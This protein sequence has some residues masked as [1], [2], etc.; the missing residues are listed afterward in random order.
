MV[1]GAIW[2]Y[3]GTDQGP[4][5]ITKYTNTVSQTTSAAEFKEAATNAFNGGA[6]SQYV[7]VSGG[8]VTDRNSLGLSGASLQQISYTELRSPVRQN[9][10]ITLIDQHLADLGTD[11]DGDGKNDSGDIGGYSVVVGLED[12]TLQDGSVQRAVRV[13][14]TL[15]LRVTASSTGTTSA[16]IQAALQSIWYAPGIG[17]VKMRLNTPQTTTYNNVQEETLLGFD[18]VTR[19]MGSSAVTALQAAGDSGSIAGKPLTKAQAA[20]AF[21]DHAVLVTGL[22]THAAPAYALT[23]VNMHGQVTHTSVHSFGEGAKFMG[24][25]SKL[26]VLESDSTCSIKLTPLDANGVGDDGQHVFITIGPGTAP[27]MPAGGTCR[28]IEYLS[29]VSDGNRIWLTAKRT[30]F[31]IAVN[32]FVRTDLLVMSID[33]DGNTVLSPTILAGLT[34]NHANVSVPFYITGFSASGGKALVRY[35]SDASGITFL[36]SLDNSGVTARNSLPQEIPVSQLQV[37][38][39]IN[40]PALFWPNSTGGAYFG[41]LLDASLNPIVTTGGTVAAQR[42]TGNAWDVPS[43]S[44]FRPGPDGS[45][46]A[47]SYSGTLGDGS[48][49]YLYLSR[50]IASGNTPL[51]AQVVNGQ[52]VPIWT[53]DGGDL[54]NFPLVVPFQDRVLL[55]DETAA[56]HIYGRVV[57]LQ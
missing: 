42:L 36:A 32:L 20:V 34:E 25:G 21:A 10:Q 30:T 6:D 4:S 33:E 54:I 53:D 8:T 28:S 26:I 3:A 38:S 56:G 23:S 39:T 49:P 11:I 51:A 5:G 24:T 55:F 2:S 37:V 29:A 17:I 31:S 35:V 19:G 41:V 14:T 46:T 27:D 9:D 40:A 12:V 47:V 48:Q 13:D 7:S 16:P 1:D 22:E 44:F 52:K 15:M 57:W 43:D 18:A 45:I 50:F